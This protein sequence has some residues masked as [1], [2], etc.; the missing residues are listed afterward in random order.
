MKEVVYCFETFDFWGR[1]MDGSTLHLYKEV[2][3]SGASREATPED[4]ALVWTPY[5]RRNSSRRISTSADA[6]TQGKN[7]ANEPNE[8]NEPHEA[9]GA[10]Q[11]DT[12]DAPIESIAAAMGWWQAAIR[13]GRPAATR[14][15]HARMAPREHFHAKPL[16]RVR[17]FQ[18][19]RRRNSAN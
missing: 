5:K 19:P 8:P 13:R 7:E 9:N 3:A 11:A 18:Q 14:A 15:V 4:D 2:E 17:I 6:L 10:T 16:V 12:V 1:R